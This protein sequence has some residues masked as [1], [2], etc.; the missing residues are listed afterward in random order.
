M[1][2]VREWNGLNVTTYGYEGSGKFFIKFVRKLMYALKCGYECFE[3]GKYVYEIT[4]V[5]EGIKGVQYEVH[6]YL[7]KDCPT[8]APGLWIIDQPTRMY[9]GTLVANVWRSRK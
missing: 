3:F 7:K 5:W 1:T 6:K 8:P 9:C 2:R 4:Y